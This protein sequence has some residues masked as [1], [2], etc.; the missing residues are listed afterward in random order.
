MIRVKLEYE[1][2]GEEIEVVRESVTWVNGPEKTLINLVAAA[3]AQML[4]AMRAK[5]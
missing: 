4:A 3:E 1:Q 5:V 2:T